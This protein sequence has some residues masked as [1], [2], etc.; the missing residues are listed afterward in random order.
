M[1]LI[2][3]STYAAWMVAPDAID[4]ATS[5]K[6][7]FEKGIDAGTGPYAID[8]YTAD[9]EVD[10]G[11]RRLLGRLGARRERCRREDRA[12]SRA[13]AATLDGGESTSRHVRPKLGDVRVQ[14]AFA[15]TRDA[16]WFNYG[17]LQYAAAAAR[18]PEGASG[19]L[20]RDPL[21]GHHRRRHARLRDPVLRGRA[22]GRVPVLGS[23][24][25][26]HDRPRRPRR[27]CRTR[28]IRVVGSPATHVRLREPG[29]GEDGAAIQ[30]SFK[31]IGVTVET[32]AILF[33][34]QWEA[35]KADPA[36]AQDISSSCTGRPTRTRARTTCTRCS[37]VQTRPSST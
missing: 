2:A 25:A 21:S 18:R 24:S 28:A 11:L 30:D 34:Q 22:Q 32:K 1:E 9:E 10:L 17:I 16:S 27:C 7:Y 26:V 5:D 14:S 13:A 4:A 20:L 33:N 3:G 37:T 31:Q 36:N 12:G 35:A 15:V 23:G 8:S 19:A 29:R 6:K